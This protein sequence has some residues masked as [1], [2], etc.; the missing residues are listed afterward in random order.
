MD[1]ETDVL[2]RAKIILGAVNGATD[3]ELYEYSTVYMNNQKDNLMSA[4]IASKLDHKIRFFADFL[5]TKFPNDAKSILLKA[6]QMS[7]N[8]ENKA[9]YEDLIF[10]YENE[11]GIDYDILIEKLNYYLKYDVKNTAKIEE[12]MTQINALNEET[13]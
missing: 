4:I 6:T 1:K 11:Y 9:Q 8:W 5:T 10:R 13:E 7:G 2:A 12:L 3:E